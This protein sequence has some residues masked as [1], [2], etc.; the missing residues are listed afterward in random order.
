MIEEASCL[1]DRH[2]AHL[3]DV[4]AID[5][6]LAS[7]RAQASSAASGA[8]RVSAIAAEKNADVQLVL[9]ALEM[10]KEAADAAKT[11]GPVLPIDDQFLLLGVQFIPRYIQRNFSLSAR[12]A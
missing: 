8:Q 10:L 6:Y 9:L 3:A 2:T 4:L 1:F 11:A 7:F 5:L 12:S